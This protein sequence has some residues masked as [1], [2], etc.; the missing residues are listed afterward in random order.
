M[1]HACLNTLKSFLTFNTINPGI[2][3]CFQKVLTLKQ[4]IKNTQV[5]TAILFYFIF[6]AWRGEYNAI[7]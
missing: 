2:S 5:T 6:T 1:N 7:A 3:L 4:G